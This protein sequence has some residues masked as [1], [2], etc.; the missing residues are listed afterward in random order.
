MSARLRLDKGTIKLAVS[1]S[2]VQAAS[3]SKHQSIRMAPR[4]DHSCGSCSQV[5]R[6]RGDLNRHKALIH[7]NQDSEM[8]SSFISSITERLERIEKDLEGF[9]T[10]PSEPQI[11]RDQ[12]DGNV[13]Q[14]LISAAPPVTNVI[15][16][17]LHRID[18]IECLIK[19][20]NQSISAKTALEKKN[21]DRIDALYASKDD[22]NTIVINQ[23]FSLQRL[24]QQVRECFGEHIATR[25]ITKSLCEVT[26]QQG[27]KFNELTSI[28]HGNNGFLLWET[29]LLDNSQAA[30]RRTL[31]LNSN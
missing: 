9:P 7:P 20:I 5:F 30:L 3:F 29:C 12:N 4:R 1:S 28:V 16:W 17:I 11:S 13:D 25:N 24:H 31:L 14:H 23:G 6:R 26:E 22:L 2:S 21:S 8:L 18:N 10:L 27:R 19:E 15:G